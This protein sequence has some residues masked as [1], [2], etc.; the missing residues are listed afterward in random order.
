MQR[1]VS[2]IVPVYNEAGAIE[3]FV[4]AVEAVDY[5]FGRGAGN[6]FC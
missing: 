6:H 2:L 3:P 5:D 4:S 1:K